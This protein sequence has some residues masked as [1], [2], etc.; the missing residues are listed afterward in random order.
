MD[1]IFIEILYAIVNLCSFL[2]DAMQEII[3]R[4]YLTSRG[5]SPE[6]INQQVN[7]I[8]TLETNLQKVSRH[9]S[10]RI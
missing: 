10:L 4:D 6:E 8:Q 1:V 7:L 5:I 3:F 2:E 9:G